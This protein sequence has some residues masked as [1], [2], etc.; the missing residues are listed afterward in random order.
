M[1]NYEN[2]VITALDSNKLD[3]EIADSI[4]IS[5]VAVKQDVLF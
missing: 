3:T 1:T 5:M 4:I 2:T